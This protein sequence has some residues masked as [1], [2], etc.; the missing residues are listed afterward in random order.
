MFSI[1]FLIIRQKLHV[2]L[3]FILIMIEVIILTS[4]NQGSASVQLAEL[5]KS[6]KIKGKRLKIAISM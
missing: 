3:I 5:V 1:S 6:E 4:S 2:K